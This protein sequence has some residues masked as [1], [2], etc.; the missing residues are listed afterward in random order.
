MIRWNDYQIRVYE[1]GDVSLSSQGLLEYATMFGT[2]GMQ[3]DSEE[4]TERYRRILQAS[5]VVA[6]AIIRLD[7]I[8]G[9]SNIVVDT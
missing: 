2:Y 7:E 1:D 8:I 4:D 6:D 9:E 5:R 3:C